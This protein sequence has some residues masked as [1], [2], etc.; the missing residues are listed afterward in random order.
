MQPSTAPASRWAELDP[1]HVS[2]V[3]G[4]LAIDPKL[5]ALPAEAG[6]AKE[7][8]GALFA[9]EAGQRPSQE[10]IREIERRAEA[11]L[12][13][14]GALLLFLY[15]RRSDRELAAVRN[16]LW[17]A[18]HVVAIYE[19]EATGTRRRTLA[20]SS[21]VEGGPAKPSHAR[22]GVL[23]VARRTREVMAP[24]TT[25]EKFD[26]GS[27]GWNGRPGTP[28][29]AHFRWMRRFV[30]D[31]ARGASGPRV[32]DFGCGAGWVGI[33]A[34]QR[35]RAQEL[36]AFDPSPA[37]V[38]QAQRN[39]AEAGIARFRGRTGFGEHPPFPATGER[40]F[41]LVISS[42]VASFA[43][44]LEP[45]V[46]GLA[47]TVAPGGVL[48]VGDVHRDSR[49]FRKRRGERPLVPVREMNAHTRGEVRALLEARGFRH[50]ASAGYQLT[51]PV[52][53]LMHLS[54]MKLRGALS[55][56][57]LW[58]NQLCAALDGACGGRCPDAFDSWVMRLR[59]A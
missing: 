40:S 3:L 35:L 23:L 8:P 59:R 34:A 39:A 26:A 32:L 42:G 20:G 30:A 33:E 9:L 13:E 7:R 28:G 4:D 37:M 49:G 10:T 38:A 29:Y 24:D 15:G 17:A 56:P 22:S 2:H 50:E 5:V 51:R 44:E 47:S 53:E 16:S 14:R 11:M 45:W 1:G 18:F 25:V 31:F 6:S 12:G 41:E 48:V 43:P 57:L 46:E 58:A 19:L 54:E 27:A 21:A 36:C 55:R 52:P